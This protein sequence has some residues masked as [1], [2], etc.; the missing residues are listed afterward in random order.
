MITLFDTDLWEI[1]RHPGEWRL[2]KPGV[3]ITYVNDLSLQDFKAF[4]KRKE[5]SWENDLSNTC[6]A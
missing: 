2:Y 3:S 1:Q 6:C 5:K 4:L